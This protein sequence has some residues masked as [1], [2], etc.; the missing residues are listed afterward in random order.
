M[1]TFIYILIYFSQIS[2]TKQPSFEQ[3]NSY[4]PS[5]VQRERRDSA[6]SSGSR[7]STSNLSMPRKTAVKESTKA[8]AKTETKPS[9]Q[10]LIIMLFIY[11]RTGILFQLNRLKMF[12]QGC[13][14]L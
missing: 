14:Q 13:Q 10:V 12:V 4:N 1:A 3:V 8:E 5:A 7:Y 2:D 6:L 11:I 9:S